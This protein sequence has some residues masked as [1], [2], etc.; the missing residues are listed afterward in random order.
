MKL[1]TRKLAWQSV[2][3]LAEQVMFSSGKQMIE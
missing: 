1:G 2:K 3:D